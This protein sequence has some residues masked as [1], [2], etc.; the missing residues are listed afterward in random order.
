MLVA[1]NPSPH[2]LSHGE[3]KGLTEHREQEVSPVFTEDVLLSPP[4][5]DLR[6][7]DPADVASFLC[8]ARLAHSSFPCVAIDKGENRWHN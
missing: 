1:M 6:L 7:T 4:V 3:G 5:P 8:S 2:D